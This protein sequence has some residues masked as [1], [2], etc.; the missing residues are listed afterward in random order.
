MA[1][2]KFR[3]VSPG[4]QF[5]EIDESVI[6]P[7]PPAIGPLVIGRTAK[8]PS[9][10]PVLVNTVAE[11]ERVFGP[12]YNGKVGS[13]DVW[14]TG[15][16][17]SPTL[18]T[19]AA[20]AF[21]RNSGPVTVIRLNGVSPEASLSEDATTV[22]WA[23][24]L[25]GTFGLF[26]VNAGLATLGAVIYTSGS[27]VK[28]FANT[29]GATPSASGLAEL[30]GST[31]RI[32]IDSVNYD[33]SLREGTTFVRDVL[34]TNPTKIYT[35]KYFL[36][37]TFENNVTASY[38][39]V[40]LKPLS[41]ID[42]NWK[43]Y[44]SG[45]INAETGWITGDH[46]TGADPLEL[47]KFVGLDNG[48]SLSK[49]IKIS[50]ENVRA[51]KNAA[52]T[53]YGTFDVVIRSLFETSNTT[54]TVLERFSGLTLDENSDSYI[55]KVI[56]DSYR[57]WDAVNLHYVEVGNY[58][59]RSAYVRVQMASD[60][61]SETAL[62]H[63]FRISSRPSI[64]GSLPSGSGVATVLYPTA[65][66]LTSTVNGNTAK[67]TR[68]GLVAHPTSNADLI[69]ILRQKPAVAVTS[70]Q[71]FST[72]FIS[73][74]TA[75]ANKAYV[76]GT[77][78]SVD[79]LTQG[80]IQGFNVPVYGGF[81]GVDIF[82]EEPFVNESLL[83]TSATTI[84]SAAYRTIKRAI[85]IT[86]DT[87]VLD[88]SLLCVPGLKNE[89]LTSH[90]IEV[91]RNRGD[92]M[93]LIDLV[94]DYKYAYENSGVES[95]PTSVTTVISNLESRA[96]D[97][98][99][100]A[101]YFPAVFVQRE[102]IFM[103]ASIAAL[104]AFGGTEGRS[105][106]WFAP[107]GFS[108]GGLTEA[109]SGLGVSRT[110]LQLNASD[111]DLLYAANINPIATFPNEG[112]VIFGQKT[113]Q[114]T[115]S[116]LDRVNVRRLLNFIKKQISRVATR[117]LFEPNVEDTWNNFKGVVNPFLAAIKAN[118]GLDDA[119][120]I[121]DSSTTTADLIDRNTLYCKILLKPTRAIEFIAIDFVV[122]NSGASFSEQ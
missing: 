106:L 61:I 63:G 95:K 117:V 110:A 37:E 30:T 98:S 107:A 69:D 105:A 38:T 75:V 39:S 13:T 92:S 99:Y 108:R 62:P 42:S 120:V 71:T 68:F 60:N 121:L 59:N 23:N 32:Q 12:S 111:R 33:V 31:V 109:S 56:G 103:P 83:G 20:E 57:F 119:R 76:S 46:A 112:V 72:R 2:E 19:Y 15:I 47:F 53:K 24:V 52:V 16:P 91:C 104:G 34:N 35:E 100:G 86:S 18:G 122:T 48:S 4:V 27:I 78:N 5:N 50:I 49:E 29:G 10:Q 41:E 84:N 9:M 89:S 81:D 79:V 1:I 94:G 45:A 3:F 80:F 113:L 7:T 97:N 116:A 21:L 40:I 43:S 118:Y 74:G 85:D 17:T 36:G 25:S 51:T 26:A 114:Q 90:M 115:P 55:A 93:A 44:V 28:L 65:S 101:T 14:R 8:G 82:Q 70:Q 66:L 22:G 54:S 96:I 77:Y 87:E 67:T 58:P 64:T 102:A 88:M 6:A 11:L 73:G